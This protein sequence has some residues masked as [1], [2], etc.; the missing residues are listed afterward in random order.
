MIH[1]SFVLVGR[2]LLLALFLLIVITIITGG[3]AVA[4]LTTLQLFRGLNHQS[5]LELSIHCIGNDAFPYAGS[6][7]A[8]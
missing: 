3:F 8:D 5:G 6:S 4:V 1:I 2:L 7:P